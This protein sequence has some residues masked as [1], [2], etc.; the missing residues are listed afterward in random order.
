MYVGLV[1][2]VV[3]VFALVCA[4]LGGAGVFALVCLLLVPMFGLWLAGTRVLPV[5]DRVVRC[6]GRARLLLFQL[7]PPASPLAEKF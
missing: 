3:L 2:L 5:P 1:L 6:A 7:P 4:P